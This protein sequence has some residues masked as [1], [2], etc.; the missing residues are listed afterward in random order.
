MTRT[1]SPRRVLVAL[2]AVVLSYGLMQTMLVPAIGALQVQLHT[3]AT[4]ASWAVLSGMLLCSAVVTPLIGRLADRYGTRRVLLISLTVYLAGAVGAAAAPTI[5]VL[6][7]CRVVQGVSLA[8]LPLSFAIVREAVPHRLVPRGLAIT[9][10]LVTGTA[11]VGLLLGGLVVDH[12]SWRWLFV[13]GAAIIATALGLTIRYVPDSGRRAPGR[14]DVP[15]AALLAAGLGALLL[16]ITQGPTWGWTAV[17]TLGL[18]AAAALVLAGFVLVELRVPDPLVDPTLLTRGRLAVA[19]LGALALGINQF[20]LYVLLPRLAELPAGLPPDAARLVRYGFGT[21]VT[22]AALILLPGT[23]LTMPA[24]WT[25]GRLER[26][27]GMVGP[28]AVGLGLAALGAAAIAARHT[29]R[30]QVVVCYLVVSLGYGLAM[31]ALPRL[32]NHASPAHQ[33]GTANGV[34]TVARTLGGAIG[35]QVAAAA[36]AANTLGGTVA[37]ADRGFTLGFALAA[38][39]AAAGTV[40][41]P[42]ARSRAA[43]DTV[44]AVSSGR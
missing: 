26:R 18:F 35:S 36:L 31:A 40:V 28:L 11:G 15:G 32:V 9:S 34:N 39:A 38:A 2:G 5:G 22:V 7:G 12:A 33:A 13:V 43:A 1:A 3:S 24:S 29:A 14:L 6:I 4:A 23:L 37:P 8:L 20:V 10:G 17:P 21:S 19:H 27:L 42:L 44:P 25:A 41:L 16:G 30:W